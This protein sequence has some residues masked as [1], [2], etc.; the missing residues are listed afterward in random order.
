MSKD[1]CRIRKIYSRYA[2]NTT[3]NALWVK[4]T[5]ALDP[6]IIKRN[7]DL[8]Y[9][10]GNYFQFLLSIKLI[11]IVVY[12]LN[13]SRHCSVNLFMNSNQTFSHVPNERRSTGRRTR[14]TLQATGYRNQLTLEQRDSSVL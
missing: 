10:M 7:S 11:R 12:R 4:I 3:C 9:V 2:R 8:C 1:G 14:Q 6:F 5:P 13:C